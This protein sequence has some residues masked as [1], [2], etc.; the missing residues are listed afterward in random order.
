M[1]VDFGST[2]AYPGADRV[3]AEAMDEPLPADD[4]RLAPLYRTLAGAPLG[5]AALGDAI[6]EALIGPLGTVAAVN[7][8]DRAYRRVEMVGTAAIDPSHRE[9]YR[10][11]LA[12]VPV[13]ERN[14]FHE[15]STRREGVASFDLADPARPAPPHRPAFLATDARH[16][17]VASLGRLD[18]PLGTVQ[19]GRATPHTP[20]E[21]RLLLAAGRLC[22]PAVSNAL[23]VQR[24]RRTE[25][26]TTAM[27]GNIRLVQL[28]GAVLPELRETLHVDTVRLLLLSAD[29]TTLHDGLTI[30]A[31]LHGD[32]DVPVGTGFAGKI[33]AERRRLIVDDAATFPIHS[34]PLRNLGLAS[35]AG[36]PVADEDLFGVLHIGSYAPRRFGA[37][38]L[39]VLQLVADRLALALREDRTER[40]LRRSEAVARSVL[41]TAADAIITFGPDGIVRSANRSAQRLLGYDHDELVGMPVTELT[42]DETTDR[43]DAGDPWRVTDLAPT[44]RS[45][46]VT[47]RHAHGTTFP[48]DLTIS[49]VEVSDNA[50][51]F[52]AIMRDASERVAAEERLRHLALHDPLTGLPNRALFTEQ[53]GRALG[54]YVRDGRQVAVM[55]MDL[56]R[57]KMINDTLGHGAGDALLRDAAERLRGSVRPADVLARLG[58]DEFAVLLEGVVPDDPV[59]VARRILQVFDAPFVIEDHTLHISTSIGIAHTRP[60]NKS[61]TPTTLLRDAD[62]ALYR[63]KAQG[64][65]RYDIFDDAMRARLQHR[66]QI[67]N[68]LHAALSGGQIGVH[69]QPLL[70]LRTGRISS[71]E[72]LV[73]WRHPDHGALPA[74]QFV[75]IAEEVG[76]I[77]ALGREV[78]AQVATQLRR[79]ERKLGDDAP[80]IA[81]N[82]SAS[83]L[84]GPIEPLLSAAE[85]QLGRLGVEIT[86]TVLMHDVERVADR[87]RALKARGVTI[88]VDDF[89]TGYSSLAYLRRLPIDV[90]KID[91]TFVEGVHNNADDRAIVH[92]IIEL[93]HALGMTVVAEGVETSKQ[94]DALMDLNCDRAQGYFIAR[95]AAAPPL[96]LTP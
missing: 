68:E 34:T 49:A 43:S 26:I 28:F 47:A 10:Q 60:H 82:L 56:D 46:E 93:G 94:L 53:I 61:V 50:Q 65:A 95:P 88:I 85:G 79:W 39:E 32:G 91:K 19:V 71:Y 96:A 70:D 9:Q 69:Y 38:D 7:L 62:A 24:L 11:F 45:W 23:L 31:E 89:G 8:Y 30:G 18:Q 59:S 40:A 72:A 76:L 22:G 21:T 78:T 35:L 84:I 20:D 52:T 64:R 25:R 37:G 14:R 63:A 1:I 66:L 12:A 83:Q 6:A 75:R 44:G 27:A 58:G 2:H 13:E 73:R 77:E 54:N 42:S 57:F 86:E 5:L 80:H 81:V 55:F 67:E 15:E 90:V 3:A 48:A 74:E 17:L 29:G 4:P 51:L 36:V 16:H 87:L 41:E 33:A 92:S